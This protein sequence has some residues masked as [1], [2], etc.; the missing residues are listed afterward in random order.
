MIILDQFMEESQELI[1]KS[2]SNTKKSDSLL[3]SRG[4]DQEM[5]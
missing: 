1:G 5:G 3:Y 2:R 4:K